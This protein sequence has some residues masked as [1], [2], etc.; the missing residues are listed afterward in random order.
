MWDELLSQGK[1][2]WAVGTDDA[3]DYIHP[4]DLNSERPGKAWI[5]VR[6]AQLTAD[7]IL[8]AIREGEF[9]A[10]NGVYLE[11][12]SADRKSISI[13][14]KQPP[15][16]RGIPMNRLFTTKFVGKGGRVLAELGGLKPTYRI[17]GDEGYVRASIIDSN[18]A[19]AW[20]QPAT[21]TAAISV[22]RRGLL[23]VVLRPVQNL[24]R[25]RRRSE[26]CRR[27]RS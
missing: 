20:T 21:Q 26:R 27:L 14:L 11:D 4:D 6:A 22:E 18:G 12:Y 16:P 5:T 8:T 17:R 7:T 1:V 24:V 13:A 9:Y 3:H 2:V 19:R 10:S 25:L 15:G 23:A